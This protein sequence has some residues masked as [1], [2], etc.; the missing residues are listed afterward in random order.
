MFSS[1][2]RV[3]F[4][5]QKVDS[6]LKQSRVNADLVWLDCLCCL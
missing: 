1:P 3:I 5:S 6:Q 2:A 4:S